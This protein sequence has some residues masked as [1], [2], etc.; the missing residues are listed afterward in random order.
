VP[1]RAWRRGTAGKAGTDHGT[2]LSADWMP[3]CP[4][5]TAASMLPL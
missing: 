4:S 5:L 2:L 3:D 1:S